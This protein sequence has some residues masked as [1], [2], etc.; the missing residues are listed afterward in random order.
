[1]ARALVIEADAIVGV[2]AA[3]PVGITRFLSWVVEAR[4]L[5]PLV[6]MVIAVD[7]AS[8]SRFRRGEIYEELTRSLPPFHVE[9]LADDRRVTEAAWD[10]SLARTGPFT[11]AVAR[12][13]ELVMELPRATEPLEVADD[14]A[15][16]F[17]RAS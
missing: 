11:R 14:A 5:A 3:T 6:P 1:V 17:E 13:G 9:F 10:G 8:P 12:L 2:C 7:R 4:R 15:E 16:P